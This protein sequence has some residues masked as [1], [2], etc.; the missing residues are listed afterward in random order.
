MAVKKRA[1]RN[2]FGSPSGVNAGQSFLLYKTNPSRQIHLLL[3]LH[4]QREKER[5]EGDL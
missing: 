3:L 1:T 2:Q 4:T 5:G